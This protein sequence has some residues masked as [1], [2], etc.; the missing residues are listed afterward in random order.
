MAG[1]DRDK[2]ARRYVFIDKVIGK[3]CNTQPGYR[4]NGK[5]YSAVS[6]EAP[7]RTNGDDFVAIHE[8]PGFR[9]LHEGLMC[10]QILRRFREPMRLYIVRAR[11]ELPIE[12]SDASCD[13]V[14]VLKRASPDCTIEPLGDEIDEAVTVGGVDVELRVAPCHSREH[15]S[16]VGR[17]ERKRHGNSQAAAKIT[18]GQDRFLGYFDL[19]T[20]PGCIVS[21]CGPGFCESGSAGG[22]CQE[23]DAKFCFKSEKPATDD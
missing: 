13:Q 21:E 5:S 3:R 22:S 14:R 18:G 17:T 7:L 9:S 20:G 1:H 10:G 15:G 8:S 4:G 16:E 11:D 23:L 19:G 6:L 12:R 2:R